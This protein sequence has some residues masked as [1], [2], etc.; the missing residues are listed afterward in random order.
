[1]CLHRFCRQTKIFWQPINLISRAANCSQIMS[2]F[3]KNSPRG[4]FRP[5]ALRCHN[6][7]VE[8]GHPSNR[9]AT[10][11]VNPS[12]NSVG[13]DRRNVKKAPAESRTAAW[14]GRPHEGCTMGTVVAATNWERKIGEQTAFC[15][16]G[17]AI[18][19]WVF[20]WEARPT[21]QRMRHGRHALSPLC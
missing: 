21:F 17:H 3:S 15:D 6:L 8:S 14:K 11:Q 13:R 18:T 9:T 16:A 5:R 4:V 19:V 20:A 12:L 1:M 7:Q 10:E 2:L